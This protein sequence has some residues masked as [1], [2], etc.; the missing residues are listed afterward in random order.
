MCPCAKIKLNLG[1]EGLILGAG[2]GA[3]FGAHSGVKAAAF[4]GRD[5]PPPPSFAVAMMLSFPPGWGWEE[6]V[7]VKAT[8]RGGHWEV[9]GALGGHNGQEHPRQRIY[10]LWSED[11]PSR[12][13]GGEGETASDP[14]PAALGV[15]R[16]GG[17][18][19]ASAETPPPALGCTQGLEHPR[20]YSQ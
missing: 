18:F 7:K 20:F 1:R 13:G 10:S 9:N 2:G 12:G 11:P 6:R 8:P 14:N 15:L 4:G 17:R 3:A 19:G 5:T 16:S